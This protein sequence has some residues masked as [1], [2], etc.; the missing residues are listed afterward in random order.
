MT[1]WRSRKPSPAMGVAVVALIVAL[2]GTATAA[3]TRSNGDKIIRKHSL[4]GNR[5]KNHTITGKQL[6]LSKLGNV[7]QPAFIAPALAPGFRNFGAGYAPAGYEKDTLGFVHLRGVLH[8]SAGGTPFTLP[9]GYRPGTTVEFAEA[10]GGN[11]SVLTVQ[12]FG[13]V[14]SACASHFSVGL[15]GI[16]FAA[17]GTAGT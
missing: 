8:C 13:A 2:G 1:R 12:S 16:V 6:N 4:S 10:D 15:D 17:A 9:P 11:T 3:L 7:P 5:L 14:Q